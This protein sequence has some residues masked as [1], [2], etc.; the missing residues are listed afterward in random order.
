MMKLTSSHQVRIGKNVDIHARLASFLEDFVS[1]HSFKE[2]IAEHHQN[3]GLTDVSSGKLFQK[4]LTG[5]IGFF[6]KS[7]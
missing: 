3:R 2:L 7:G 5:L 6:Q 1:S 4:V